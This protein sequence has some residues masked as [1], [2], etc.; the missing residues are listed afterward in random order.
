MMRSLYSAVSGLKTHQSKMDVIG[1]N[2][3]NVNTVAFKSTS[4]TFN[5]V[6][7]QTTSKASGSNEVTGTGGVNAKQIGLGVTT[8]ATKIAISTEGATQ[9]TGDALDLKISGTNFFVV[10]NGSS[11]YFTRDGSFYIDGNGNLCMSSTGYN[12]MGWQAVTDSDT[13]EIT[14]Q[15]DTV[16]KLQ[17]MTAANLVSPPEATTAAVASGIIDNNSSALTNGGYIMTLGFYDSLGYSYTAKFVVDNLNTDSDEITIFDL[18]LKDIVDSDGNSILD[19]NQDGDYEDDGEVDPTALFAEMNI[20]YN[21]ST[22]AFSSATCTD[23]ADQ[24]YTDDDGDVLGVNLLLAENTTLNA[25][26]NFENIAIDFT[27][28]YNY[29]NDGTSTLGL[30]RGDSDG[31]NAGYAVGSMTGLSISNNGE[32]YG[33][34]DNGTTV[35]LCQIA[36]ASFAN[37]SG[38]E[39]LGNNCYAETLN[40]GEFDGVGEDVTANS[41]SMTSGVLEMSNVDLS[42]EFTEMITTQRGFQANSRV[43][44]TSDTLLEELINLK[45]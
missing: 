26:L 16:S 3:A 21:A 14:I 37:P 25:D 19:L 31:N 39:S 5:D 8:A 10:S 33:T 9:T 6:L 23:N 42:S 28:S 45:R 17:P 27:N 20:V 4:V 12:V 43:I 41:G 29:D 13:G 22:G 38:L 18:N 34:Y 2:I 7:Y 15:K 1:N 24:I 30:D 35:L 40:S 32:I 36:S 11:N 44:T